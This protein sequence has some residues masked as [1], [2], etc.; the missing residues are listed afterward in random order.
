M[1]P[2]GDGVS[3]RRQ[4]A[5]GAARGGRRRGCSLRYAGLAAAA[6]SGMGNS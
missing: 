1:A 6:G 4:S 2:V 5:T 3:A